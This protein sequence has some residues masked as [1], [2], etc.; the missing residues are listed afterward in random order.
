[1][2]KFVGDDRPEEQI[3]EH[4]ELEKRLATLLRNAGREERRQL[5]GQ[6]YDKLYSSLPHHPRHRCSESPALRMARVEM[7]IEILRPFLKREMVAVELGPGTCHTLC[8][9]A[10][11]VNR[12]LGVDVSVMATNRQNFP[13]NL[14]LLQF[15][16]INI[17]I[18]AE[19]ADLVYSMAVMEHLHPEDALEQLESV[20]K[21]LKPG[22]KYIFNTT[23]RFRGPDD[24]SR[25]FDKVA[26]G[27]HLHE[28][29]FRELGRLGRK[30]GFKKVYGLPRFLGRY[31]QTGPTALILF[32]ALLAPLPYGIRHWLANARGISSILGVRAVAVK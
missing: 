27:F 3:R 21:V 18:P 1:M 5:Y 4:Y 25:H 19:S 14:E 23:H 10:G 28:Y 15:D 22:G 16:G 32:E 11:K 8:A 13:P 24:I 30:A 26:T 2:R 7:Q 6:V 9:V 31:Y 12:A 20:V 17:P 29:T